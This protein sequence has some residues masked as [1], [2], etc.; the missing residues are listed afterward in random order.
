MR[1]LLAIDHSPASQAA[2]NEVAS[3]PWPSDIAVEVLSAIESPHDWARAEVSGEI[4]RL[5]E[6][7][8][9]RAAQQLR[10]A[11]LAATAFVISGDPKSAIVDRAS[12]I[13][14]DWIVLGS[15]GSGG[16]TQF[17]MGSIA[18][19]VVRHAHCSLEVVRVPEIAR[20]PRG[21]KLLLAT[22]GS[23]SAA[24]AARSIASRP[25]PPDTEV[26]IFTVV[27]LALTDLQAAFEPPLIDN[28]TK[29]KIREDA[30]RHAQEAIREAAEI[31]APSPLKTSD[32]ISV[33]TNSPKQLILDEARAFD[34]DLIVTGSHGLSGID[35]FMLGSTSEAVA[36]HAECSVEV[37]RGPQA[38]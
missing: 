8:V 9:Q 16:L 12:A 2:V 3:R 15:H 32:S 1:I 28:E 19:S 7:L 5:T 17:L 18:R 10:A 35:R 25:W 14:A 30:M 26:E 11:G 24:H 20:G 31:L 27:E 36:T 4:Q 22:D 37:I 38:G 29:D 13:G 21:M 6:S 33:L 34:A 23:P